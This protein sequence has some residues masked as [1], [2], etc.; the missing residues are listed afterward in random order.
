MMQV[1]TCRG[2][3]RR[4]RDTAVVRR[5]LLPVRKALPLSATKLDLH[6]SDSRAGL[7]A[8]AAGAVRIARTEDA[9]FSFV[10]GT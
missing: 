4:W 9:I 5:T 7:W 1:C 2:A 3:C 8:A 6:R 10:G